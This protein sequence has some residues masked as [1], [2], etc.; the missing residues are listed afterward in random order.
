[1]K[2]YIGGEQSKEEKES[3][4]NLPPR[5]FGLLIGMAAQGSERRQGKPRTDEERRERHFR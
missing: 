4:D 5:G 2:L 3:R 1:M